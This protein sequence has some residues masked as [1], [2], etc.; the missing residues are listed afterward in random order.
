[1]GRNVR[2]MLNAISRN[3]E[4]VKA[5]PDDYDVSDMGSLDCKVQKLFSEAEVDNHSCGASQ[6]PCMCNGK[7]E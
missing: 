2:V 6:T 7:K 3:I 5:S 1:M 4:K